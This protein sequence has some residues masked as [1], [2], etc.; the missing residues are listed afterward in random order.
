MHV[1]IGDHAAIDEF[2]A[3]E[4]ARQLD[5]LLLGHLARDCEFDLARQLRIDPLLGRLDLVPELFAVGEVFR[6][7][8]G[9]QHF[10]VNDAGLVR[11]VVGAVEPLIV[12]PRRRAIG[13]GCQR[14]RARCA[15][16]DFGREVVDRHDGTSLTLQSGRRHDV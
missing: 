12:Q 5:A 10:G 11:E 16:D 3:H 13:G 9:Q 2:V 6:R 4:V 14:R 15:R 1:Q 7:A 8:V